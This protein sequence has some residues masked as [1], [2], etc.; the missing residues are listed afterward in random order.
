MA[1]VIGEV[2]KIIDLCLKAGEHRL[3]EHISGHA[4]IHGYRRDYAQALYDREKR[5]LNEL[6]WTDIYYC[7]GS[8]KGLKYDKIALGAVS[9]ALGHSRLSVCAEHYIDHP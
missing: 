1:P 3:F 9:K 8:R 4:D 6:E 7:R 5:S 2:D